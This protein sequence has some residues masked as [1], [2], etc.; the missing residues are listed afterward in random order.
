MDMFKLR[1]VEAETPDERVLKMARLVGLR[2]EGVKVK[3]FMWDGEFYSQYMM[4]I[5]RH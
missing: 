4:A 2:Y 1:R 5:T 3:D